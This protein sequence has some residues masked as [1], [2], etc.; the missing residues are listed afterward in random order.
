MNLKASFAL[1]PVLA[2]V[3]I[4]GASLRACEEKEAQCLIAQLGDQDWEAREAAEKRL[5]A[6]GDAARGALRALKTDDPE[7]GMRAV[8]VLSRTATCENVATF[9]EAA[10]LRRRLADEFVSD[11]M[12]GDA[13]AGGK[14]RERIEAAW[15]RIE[16]LVPAEDRDLKLAELRMETGVALYGSYRWMR[17]GEG[18]AALA[19]AELAAAVDAYGKFLEGH[20]GREDIEA[21][22]RQ[23]L[24]M[25]YGSRKMHAID[26]G[27]EIKQR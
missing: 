24:M 26:C 3:L 16:S 18:I 12:A 4:L 22:Q 10:A 27:S 17:R 14:A 15:K 8:R 5:T 9:E 6:L 20:P 1:L 23:A 11:V 2:A 25:Q 19:Q 7:V 13:E 21:R